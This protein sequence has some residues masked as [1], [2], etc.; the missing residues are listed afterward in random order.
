MP[1]FPRRLLSQTIRVALA[2]APVAV[3]LTG[4]TSTDPAPLKQ[5]ARGGFLAWYP[6]QAG[7][8]P[9]QV[10][11]YD[12]AL[13]EK[14]A[15]AP[16][17]IG[18]K[19][20]FEGADEATTAELGRIPL[21]VALTTDY[22]Q[23]TMSRSG[24]FSAE[25][26]AAGVTGG[27]A[28]YG[29]GR[30]IEVAAADVAGVLANPTAES[31]GYAR[32]VQLARESKPGVLMIGAVVVVPEVVYTLDCVDPN[33]VVAQLPRLQGLT[34]AV[35]TAEAISEKQA[36]LTLRPPAGRDGLVV[37]VLPV[38]GEDVVAPSRAARERFA[39][40][41][42][43]ATSQQYAFPGGVAAVARGEAVTAA[44]SPEAVDQKYLVAIGRAAPSTRPATTAPATTA[45]AAT[46]PAVPAP[47]L[48]PTVPPVPTPP[49][50]PDPKP[51]TPE[52]PTTEAKPSDV[53]P[54]KPEE[55]KPAPTPSENKPADV[56]APA[57]PEEPKP[58]V[59]STDP[60]PADPEK[61][62]APVPAEPSKPADP[63]LVDPNPADA[64]PDGAKPAD[65]KPADP[66][67]AD[68]PASS[69]PKAPADPKPEDA[70]PGDPKPE[71]AVPGSDNK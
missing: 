43:F 59:P 44:D 25:L 39:A 48:P 32:A 49:T 69:E 71:P 19:P 23:Q 37:A 58:A 40:S 8:R 17:A 38:R 16:S 7:I 61:P 64:K 31:A 55:P 3:F 30:V 4:C 46:A 50:T 57:K 5:V 12:S 45:P 21:T 13:R 2:A 67:P 35:I 11:L 9:G 65:P 70:K 66:K 27:T 52:K 1:R 51:A 56:P 29:T 42:R 26:V 54:A 15:E 63:K 33:R 6:A 14:F 60:K 20:A 22:A 62:A 68:A 34:D 10:Y 53:P 36:K 28:T 18:V 47:E 24:P 41:A